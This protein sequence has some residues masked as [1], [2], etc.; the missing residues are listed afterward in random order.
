MN[1]LSNFQ[2]PSIY[3]TEAEKQLWLAEYMKAVEEELMKQSAK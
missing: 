1:T 3:A 2:A